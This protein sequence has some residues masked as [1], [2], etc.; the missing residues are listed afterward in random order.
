MTI[1][2]VFSYLHFW[3]ICTLTEV[4]EKKLKWMEEDQGLK[5]L[6][7]DVNKQTC[8]TWP[9]GKSVPKTWPNSLTFT[10]YQQHNDKE[11]ICQCRRRKRWL[12]SLSLEDPLEKVMAHYSSILAWKVPWTEEPGGLQ[13]MG[14]QRVRHDWTHT[15]RTPTQTAEAVTHTWCFLWTTLHNWHNLCNFLKH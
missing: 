10:F 13:S 4:K 5:T 12:W 15:E 1:M 2:S 14:S 11:P 6:L 7:M 9:C 8:L 3:S